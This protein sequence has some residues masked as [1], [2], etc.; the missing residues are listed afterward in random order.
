MD[1]NNKKVRKNCCDCYYGCH[2]CDDCNNDHSGNDV[3]RGNK[4]KRRGGRY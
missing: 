1:F 2:R 4:R 3:L